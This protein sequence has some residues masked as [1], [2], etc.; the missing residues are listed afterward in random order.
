MG[1]Y[2]KIVCSEYQRRA[3]IRAEAF[4]SLF[5]KFSAKYNILF[6]LTDENVCLF[7]FAKKE[8]LQI[9]MRQSA[10]YLQSR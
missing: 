1:R 9:V 2:F 6:F 5:E 10:A 4:Q 7:V 8:V 3:Q